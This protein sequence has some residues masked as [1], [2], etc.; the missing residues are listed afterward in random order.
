M[1]KKLSFSPIKVKTETIA[2]TM[3][4]LAWLLSETLKF[5]MYPDVTSFDK[6]NLSQ[7]DWLEIEEFEMQLIDFQSSSMWIQ[8]FIETRKELESIETERLT[9][10]INKNANNK[11]LETWNS[12][13]DTFNCL[14][15]LARA[16]LTT[17]SSTIDHL[18]ASHYFQ[19]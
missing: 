7:F 10:N 8:K 4:N 11:I 13:P 2:G 3:I 14:K 6:L 12:L 5:I 16:I 17:F 19:R 18:P 15:K 1:K 9:S